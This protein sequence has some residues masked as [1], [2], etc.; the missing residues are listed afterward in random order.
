[1]TKNKRKEVPSKIFAFSCLFLLI[2]S[3][4]LV[5]G[6]YR[7]TP[8]IYER[9]AEQQIAE[10][11]LELQDRIDKGST[12]DVG[13]AFNEFCEK[14]DVKIVIYDEEGMV[15]EISGLDTR[16]LLDNVTQNDDQMFHSSDEGQIVKDQN[17]II[18]AEVELP[19][20]KAC[21]MVVS[22]SER[23]VASILSDG[24]KSPMIIMFIFIAILSVLLSVFYTRLAISTGRLQ[25][26]LQELDQKNAEL[27]NELEYRRKIEQERKDFFRAA[28]H[29]LKTPLTILSGQLTGMLYNVGMYSDHNTYLKKALDTTKSMEQKVINMMDISMMEG[30]E[31]RAVYEKV[32]LCDLIRDALEIYGSQ[33]ADKKIELDVSMETHAYSFGDKRL[34]PKVF[35]NVI[36]NAVKYSEEASQIRIQITQKQEIWCVVI[37]NTGAYIEE[38]KLQEIF[39]P[40]YRLDG[41]RNTKTGGTGLGLYIVKRILQLHDVS[42]RLKN[43]EEGVAFEAEF[44]LYNADSD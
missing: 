22:N 33:I 44:P 23:S 13:K 16:H 6:I 26:A 41:S 7:L 32:D 38:D 30:E 25:D 39:Q 9:S 12:K 18:G 27:Q 2:C 40:F 4:I 3:T 19:D 36:E 10:G 20:G 28:S 8:W 21:F 37:E 5:Y 29:E 17:N 43:T 24:L 34:L 31:V 35:G 15:L 1:M 42:Y 14:Y 11:I